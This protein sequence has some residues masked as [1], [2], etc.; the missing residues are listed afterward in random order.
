MRSCMIM[1][2]RPSS[3]SGGTIDPAIIVSDQG[4]QLTSDKNIV[5][6]TAKEDP[7][8]RDRNCISKRAWS[9]EPN[10]DSYQQDV[11]TKMARLRGW[12]K[13]PKRP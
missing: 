7:G 9:P 6:M 13:S 3:C 8:N 5:A 10:G 12:F 11:N 2:Q 4:S 1:E